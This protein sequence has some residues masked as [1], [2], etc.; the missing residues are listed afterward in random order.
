MDIFTMESEYD[1]LNI[2]A[3]HRPVKNPRAVLQIVHGMA[4]HKE[5][6]FPF[7]EYLAGRGVASFINDHRGHG[8]SVKAAGDLGYF[9]KNGADALLSDMNQ[10]TRLARR[11]YPGAKLFMLS[12]SMGSLA[13]RAYIQEYGQDID[14][15]L[16]SGNPGYSPVAPMGVKMARRA[17]KRRGDHARCRLLTAGILGPF[18]MHAR[19]LKSV[20][21]WISSDG[22]T[23]SE[24]D[25][26]PLCGFEFYANGYEAL[27]TLMVRA[28]APG[29]PAPNKR[30]PVKFFS[31]D[32]DACMGGEKKLRAA[33][34]LLMD[35]GY[36]NVDVKLYQGMR[37]EILNERGRE[38]VYADMADTIDAWLC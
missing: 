1:G 3:A 28:N 26:D 33:A 30:M 12:H 21:A 31:G 11:A 15:L 14:G 17:Q 8:G 36:K 34:Q 2:A 5:R 16:V 38:M 20:N 22:G 35:A 24:Y 37:H 29:A 9:G 10:L 25:L 7:M 23:V 6:Y 27:L 13:A 19:S 32:D 18:V 4:E